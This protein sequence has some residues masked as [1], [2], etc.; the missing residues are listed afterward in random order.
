MVELHSTLLTKPGALATVASMAG[1]HT[2]GEFDE[3][4]KQERTD[5]EERLN[6]K[7][8]DP[9]TPLDRAVAFVGSVQANVKGRDSQI[10]TM[11]GDLRVFRW[12]RR[13]AERIWLRAS[14]YEMVVELADDDGNVAVTPKQHPREAGGRARGVLIEVLRP[15]RLYKLTL[16]N[17][18]EDEATVG[19]V[20]RKE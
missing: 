19:L 8:M 17:G 2:S 11:K 5:A 9:S 1:E 3:F 6:I 7:R 4:L 16:T 20:L 13:I 15:G 12:E 18:E 14:D 10:A